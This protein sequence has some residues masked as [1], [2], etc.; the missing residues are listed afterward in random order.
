[1]KSNSKS[2]SSEIIQE[3]KKVRR[4]IKNTERA[5][6]D[7][8]LRVE[9]KLENKIDK[10]DQKLDVKF[11]K[12]ITDVSNFAG[13]VETLEEENEIGSDQISKLN[14]RM[15]ALEPAS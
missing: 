10:V 2:E 15:T 11:D 6:R 9:E 4:E 5:L 1:M 3:I 7:E 13:R 12:V 14:K 8:M